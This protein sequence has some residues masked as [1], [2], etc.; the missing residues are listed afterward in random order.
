MD[1]VG[2]PGRGRGAR[3]CRVA[4]LRFRPPLLGLVLF[5]G[6]A[7]RIEARQG[8][9][10]NQIAGGGLVYEN[11]ARRLACAG[12]HLNFPTESDKRV[13][14]DRRLRVA[15]GLQHASYH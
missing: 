1:G 4:A 8:Q 10:T 13:N 3:F 11:R 14:T 6:F 7:P 15:V 5:T 9:D 12:A 2:T